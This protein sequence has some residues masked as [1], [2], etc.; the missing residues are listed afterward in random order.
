MVYQKEALK[1]SEDHFKKALMVYKYHYFRK[2]IFRS[3]TTL[4][5]QMRY[6]QEKYIHG[7]STPN[8][9]IYIFQR[10]YVES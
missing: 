3:D 8:W 9:S 4:I 10:M 6:G 2:G 7:M 1:Q 5:L